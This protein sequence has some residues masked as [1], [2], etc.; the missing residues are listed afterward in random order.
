MIVY[1]FR[2]CRLRDDLEVGFMRTGMEADLEPGSTRADR[3]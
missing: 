1:I 2:D 3:V